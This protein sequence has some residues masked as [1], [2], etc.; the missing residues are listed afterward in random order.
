MS[1]S[2]MG[3]D[4]Y[5]GYKQSRRVGCCRGLDELYAK[6]TPKVVVLFAVVVCLCCLLW[7]HVWSVCC[8]LQWSTCVDCLGNT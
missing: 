3:R 1:A 6:D 8:L 2:H 5:F 4:V 7:E